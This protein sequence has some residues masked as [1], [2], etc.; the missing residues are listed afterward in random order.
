MNS[1]PSPLCPQGLSP[2]STV[3]LIFP[4]QLRI[5]TIHLISQT[6]YLNSR[7]NINRSPRLGAQPSLWPQT[8]PVASSMRPFSWTNPS[9]SAAPLARCRGRPRPHTASAASARSR[10]PATRIPSPPA[11][12]RASSARTPAGL[13]AMP[14]AVLAPSRGRA[15]SPIRPTPRLSLSSA[16]QR[17]TRDAA[18]CHPTTAHASTRRPPS[19]RATRLATD[20]PLS[21]R[22]SSS[23]QAQR[24]RYSATATE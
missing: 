17:S 9:P 11:T 20:T 18:R 21:P 16:R 14:R 22:R 23:R 24:P 7:R 12:R 19:A 8:G 4:R 1:Y 13:G 10:T 6:F 15:R 5:R 3:A 2:L